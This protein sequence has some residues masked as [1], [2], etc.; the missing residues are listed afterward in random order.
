MTDEFRCC[1]RAD[2]G[3]V[4]DGVGSTAALFDDAA[5]GAAFTV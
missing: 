2:A 4:A 1:G 5:F 3:D